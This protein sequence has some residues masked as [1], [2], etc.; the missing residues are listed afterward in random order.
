MFFA[1]QGIIRNIGY[2]TKVLTGMPYLREM[3]M[4]SAKTR[5]LQGTTWEKDLGICLQGS[6]KAIINKEFMVNAIL[7]ALIKI[8][9]PSLI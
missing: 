3:C 4:D 1:E 9:R 6:G 8:L 2:I 5:Q 7:A